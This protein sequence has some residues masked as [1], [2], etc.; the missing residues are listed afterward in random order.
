[1]V[2][3]DASAVAC[4]ITRAEAQAMIVEVKGVR[5]LQGFLAA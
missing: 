1:M 5:L 2:E 3:R 4:P